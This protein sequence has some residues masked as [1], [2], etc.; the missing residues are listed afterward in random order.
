MLEHGCAYVATASVA[1]PMD[2]YRK[3]V[4]ARDIKGF[5]YIE[6]HAPCG[7]GWKFP[8]DQT[9]EIGRL[10]ARTGAWTLWEAEYGKLTLNT[11]TLQLAEGKTEMASLEDYLKLQGRFDTVM[12]SPDKD[13]MI[14]EME[15]D[16][17]N[18]LGA[19]LTRHGAEPHIA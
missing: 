1:Y 14:D 16:I 11:L 2:L 9:V 7:P 12:K 3:V 5:R 15:R 6:V 8:S 17:Q 18:E 10:A 4:K 19:L 13:A